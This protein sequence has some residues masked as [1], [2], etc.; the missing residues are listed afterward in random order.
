MKTML[1][2]I[3]AVSLVSLATTWLVFDPVELNRREADLAALDLIG[4]RA[5]P[6][7]E[8][9]VAEA[10][11]G[12]LVLDLEDG[13]P[14]SAL[15]ELEAVL[16]H[17]PR[18]WS[19]DTRDEALAVVEV[20]DL[21]AAVAS[22]GGVPGLEAVEPLIEL[23]LPEQVES[24]DERGPSRAAERWPDDPL[25]P[26]QWHLRAMG[27]EAGW[28]HTPMGQGV[29]VAVVDTGVTMVEDLRE[30]EVLEGRCFVPGCTTSEDD[31]GHGTHVAGTIAQSTHNALGVAGVAPRAK[32]LPV[33][34]LSGVG[35]GTSA[36]VAAGIDW[37]V[38]Q[39][40]DIINLSLGGPTYSRV[41]HVA[42]AKARAAGVLVVAAAGNDG[43]SRVSWPGALTEVIGVSAIGPDGEL[44][45]YSNRGA[46]VDIAAPGGNKKLPGGGVLQDTIDPVDGHAYL[47][48]QG[49]S[50]ATPHVSGALAAILSTSAVSA[51]DAERILLAGADRS[52]WDA[53]YGWGRLD[54]EH[55]L[56]LVGSS[57]GAERFAL[58]AVFAWLI[59]SVSASGLGFRIHAGLIGGTA[60]GGLFF[61]GP[62]SGWIASVLSRGVLSWPVLIF[63]PGLGHAMALGGVFVAGAVAFVA[64]PFETP[65]PWALG[66]AAGMGAHYMHAMATGSLAWGWLA[67]GAGSLV[68]AAAATASVLI[69]LGLAGTDR[70]ARRGGTDV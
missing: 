49:T 35:G 59:A 24:A 29:T 57:D 43:S 42:V 4:T 23:R 62:A 15:T 47:A 18:W 7:P 3:A 34:V 1:Q 21:A 48:L 12:T 65:R 8:V 37:A 22:L 41:V 51:D 61:L 6:V 53:G 38:D 44:A 27:A 36:G 31:N 68:L 26:E 19:V 33:K 50:M 32:I 46:G 10:R 30:T 5:E 63:G 11:P 16:G 55:S 70:I 66:L 67:G 28:R 13:S 17:A 2:T 14:E 25:Y 20:D 69:A 56:G 54:L 58:G 45:P 9:V 64:G 60:A 39:G 52:T 40:A